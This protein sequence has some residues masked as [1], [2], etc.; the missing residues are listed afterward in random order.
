MDRRTPSGIKDLG[1]LIV[2]FLTLGLLWKIVFGWRF[3]YL[4]LAA[5]LSCTIL[6][7]VVGLPYSLRSISFFKTL[8][9]LMFFLWSFA[10]VSILAGYTTMLDP[11]TRIRF[12]QETSHETIPVKVSISETELGVGD[13]T[14]VEASLSNPTY[15]T[16]ICPLLLLRVPTKFTQNFV[17]EYPTSPEN[18]RRFSNWS[19]LSANFGY[20]DIELAPGET[21]DF[22]VKLIAAETGNLSGVLRFDCAARIGKWNFERV[23][24]AKVIDVSVVP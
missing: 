8:F 12:A 4:T 10:I 9:Y 21:R 24:G 17:F 13:E 20:T 23:Y 18:T 15:E 7:L 11:G 3:S 1:R 16:M 6:L 19:R 22:R 2:L 14:F 5:A